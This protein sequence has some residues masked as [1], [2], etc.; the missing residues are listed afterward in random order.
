M[1]T[2]S[3]NT[4]AQPCIASVQLNSQENLDANL[5]QIEHAIADAST[6]GADIVVLPENACLMGKQALIGER[7]DELAAHFAKLAA[8]HGI[9]LIAGTLP[10]PYR[11][12]GAP[13]PNGKFRQTSLAFAPDGSV[14]AR[15]DKIHLFRATVADGVG[16]YDEGANFEAGERLVLAPCE[17]RGQMVNVGMMVCFDVRFPRLAQMLRQMGADLLTVPAAFTYLTGQ[18]HWQ[19]LLQ[20]RALDSQ[21]LVVGAAQGGWHTGTGRVRQTWGHSTLMG[22]DGRILASTDSTDVDA[23]GYSIVYAALDIQAQTAIR[24][25]MPIFECQRL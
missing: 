16:S 24:Q 12:D 21:C 25:A 3:P 4:P 18:A 22:A 19:L 10:C 6:H 15:Y 2:H 7:F 23:Q 11:P 1:P 17:I 14:L 8:A 9:H 20:A 13:I 5:V